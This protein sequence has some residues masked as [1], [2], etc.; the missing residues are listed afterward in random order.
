MAAQ[1]ILVIEDEPGARQALESLLGEEGYSVC[2]AATG[3]SGLERIREFRPDTV[4]CDFLL[5]DIDGLQVLRSA[6]ANGGAD[7]TFIVMTAGCGGEE[8]EDTVEREADFFFKK[9]VDLRRL[10]RVLGD[11]PSSRSEGVH[12]GTNGKGATHGIPGRS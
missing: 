4:V 1:R 11:P 10:R 6:R 3:R 2:S 7:I 12:G 9:P 8:A 5:P